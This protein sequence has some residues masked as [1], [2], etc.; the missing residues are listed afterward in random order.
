ML[1]FP[2]FPSRRASCSEVETLSHRHLLLK[3]KWLNSVHPDMS[4]T[5]WMIKTDE[6]HIND[7]V[8]NIFGEIVIHSRDCFTTKKVYCWRVR[9]GVL[10]LGVLWFRNWFWTLHLVRINPDNSFW[11][12][13]CPIGRWPYQNEAFPT[14]FKT[15]SS[16]LPWFPQVPSGS[17]PWKNASSSWFEPFVSWAQEATYSVQLSLSKV[18]EEVPGCAG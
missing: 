12:S 16:P 15:L 8:R 7:G 1:S 4:I 18:N 14:I 13:W 9:L 17:W 2:F 3:K 11:A 5:K 10:R 6:N